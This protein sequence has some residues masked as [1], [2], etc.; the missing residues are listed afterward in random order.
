M[1]VDK[2]VGRVIFFVE[3]IVTVVAKIILGAYGLSVATNTVDPEAVVIDGGSEDLGSVA[4]N[5]RVNSTIL[6]F[7]SGYLILEAWDDFIDQLQSLVGPSSMTGQVTFTVLQILS[8]L[9]DLVVACVAWNFARKAGGPVDKTDLAVFGITCITAAV[10]D[11]VDVAELWISSEQTTQ[12]WVRCC[13]FCGPPF[14]LVPAIVGMIV[15]SV[16]GGT[17]PHADLEASATALFW[18]SAYLLY[19]SWDKVIDGWQNVFV[20]YKDGEEDC[21]RQVYTNEERKKC[22]CHVTLTYCQ[23]V[24]VALGLVITIFTLGLF[25]DPPAPDGYTEDIYVNTG[26]LVIGVVSA[27]HVLADLLQACTAFFLTTDDVQFSLC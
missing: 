15:G 23:L 1:G 9:A 26:L 21:D 17:G 14:L 24:S 20:A 6:G 5:L 19:D 18:A 12:L 13:C 16:Q 7:L 27:C 3:G 11:G 25:G 22:G 10:K 8:G 2:S 4:D